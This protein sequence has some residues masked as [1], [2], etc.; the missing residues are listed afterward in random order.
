MVRILGTLL[1]LVMTGI[2]AY[3]LYDALYGPPTEVLEYASVKA[4]SSDDPGKTAEPRTR[5]LQRGAETFWQVELPG[6]TWLDCGADCAEAYRRAALDPWD[7]VE[8][9]SR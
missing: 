7:K 3:A 9:E 4:Q 2:C 6:G 8:N 5:H 1:A